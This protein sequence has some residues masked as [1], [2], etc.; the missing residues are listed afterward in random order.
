MSWT[1]LL[2]LATTLTVGLC[3]GPGESPRFNVGWNRFLDDEP[4]EFHNLPLWWERDTPVPAW[5]RG[6]YIKNGPSQKRFGTEDRWYAQYM[7][8]WAKLNKITFNGDG[9]VLYS[10]RMIETKNYKRCAEAGKIVPHVTVGKLA[11]EDWSVVEMTQGFMQGYDNTNVIFWRLGPED[12]ANASYVASTDAPLVHIMDPESLGV[13]EEHMPIPPFYWG[14]ISMMSS[15]H[16]RR[17]LG[18]DN[19]INYHQEVGLHGLDFV[20]Y[21][22]RNSVFDREEIGRFAADFVSFIH[23]ISVTPNYAVVVMYPVTMNATAMPG[24]ILNESGRII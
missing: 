6:S 11:P 8:S 23:M 19:S 22:Y 12:P 21:R 20:L 3:H 14:G 13:L 15:S 17:E 24:E 9:V 16:W 5:L 7:D 1:H 10:G 18:T 2:L 4:T